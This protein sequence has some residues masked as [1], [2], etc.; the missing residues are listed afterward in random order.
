MGELRLSILVSGQEDYEVPELPLWGITLANA[1]AAAGWGG[2]RVVDLEGPD[3]TWA[4]VWQTTWDTAADAAEFAPA[5]ESALADLVE[6]YRVDAGIDVTAAAHPD[7]GVLIVVA[8]GDQTMAA[9]E[10]GLGLG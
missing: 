9:L 8:D 6:T 5:A 7:Q 3:G 2:D 1:E 10:D 4:V